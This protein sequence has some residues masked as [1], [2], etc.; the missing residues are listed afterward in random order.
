MGRKRTA[1]RLHLLT[2]KQVQ[3][4]KDGDHSDGGSLLLRVR[5]ESSAWIFRYTSP[6]GKRREMGLG[7][8]IR[9]SAAQAGDSLSN[10][11]KRA[12]EARQV[13]QDGVDPIDRRDAERAEKAAI[14]EAAKAAKER[15]RWT[16]CRSARDYHERVIEPTRTDRHSAQWI[17]SLENHIPPAIWN[18]PIADIDAPEL[19][20]A[21]MA[22]KPH[23]RARNL[24]GD[25][26]P[27]T[28]QRIRQRLD[29]VFEDAIFHKRCTANPA[30]A[31]RR[32]MRE[33]MPRKVKGQFAALPYSEAPALMA[34]LRTA[35]GIAARCLE[36]AMLTAAR[37]GEVLEATWSEFDLDALTWVVPPEHMKAGEP[38]TVYL[39][40][41]A[42]ELLQTVKA[43]QLHP[44]TVFP[45]FAARR[46]GKP[47]SNMAMLKVLDRL[48][49]R[50]KTTVHG[51]CRAT[52]STWAYDTAA[53]RP[54]VIE[55][56][57]AHRET[58][59]IKAAYCRADFA[60]E[61]RALLE[62]W[63]TYLTRPALALVAA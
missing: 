28:Q 26:L 44:E 25:S 45:S 16:L 14:V 31:I 52:F 49:V 46:E 20:Q 41:R 57:L 21:L 63:S 36:L 6:A 2:V 37:T 62:A 5:G 9:G 34:R 48:G 7:V 30:A 53:A 22:I 55:A 29:A 51:L 10:A 38:H 40:T 61:R 23:A 17:S 42:V 8:A 1:A 11:R 56:C 35:P 50:D 59:R 60:S 19:L 18:K 58:D 24:R 54:D 12:A 27:E 13:L 43:Q 4:A 32:K 33:E 3:A 39:P 15:E 47:L